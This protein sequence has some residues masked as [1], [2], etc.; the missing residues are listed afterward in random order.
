MTYNLHNQR[1]HM[2]PALKGILRIVFLLFVEVLITKL[3][4]RFGDAAKNQSLYQQFLL[5]FQKV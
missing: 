3:T 4:L 5:I 1:V 2:E